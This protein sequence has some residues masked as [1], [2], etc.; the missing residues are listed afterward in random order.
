MKERLK[1]ALFIDTY[2]PMIDGVVMV[3][4]NYAKR[5]QKYADVTV[6][7][8]TV[9]KNFKDNHSY[10]VVRCKSFKPFFL[11]YVAPLPRLDRKF[12]K[13]IKNSHFDIVHIHSPFA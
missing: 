5:L 6:F 7:C 8:P 2:F 11:D 13:Y 1:I 10:K 4:D 3:V 12:K 9:D